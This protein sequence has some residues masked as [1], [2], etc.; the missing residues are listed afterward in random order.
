MFRENT[1][2]IVH[3]LPTAA[4]ANVD[5][6]KHYVRIQVLSNAGA[7]DR[8]KQITLVKQLTEL[9]AQTAAAAELRTRTWVLLTEAAP[10]RMGTVG[11]PLYQ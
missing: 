10:R 2:A 11:K 8:G 9:V 5:G 3:E 6:D 7:L 1:P 4:I